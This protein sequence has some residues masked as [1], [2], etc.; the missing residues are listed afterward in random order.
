MQNR[1]IDNSID[2]NSENNKVFSN[3]QSLSSNVP[4]F[5]AETL[6]INIAETKRMCM[7]YFIDVE[8][9]MP[10]EIISKDETYPCFLKKSEIQLKTSSQSRMNLI[11]Y[12][13]QNVFD[14]NMKILR[15]KIVEF[16]EM[17]NVGTTID[18][19]YKID[20]NKL[21]TIYASIDGEAPFEFT[22]EEA[23]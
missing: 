2:E 23:D 5:D 13:G 9:N 21:I 10:I 12:E 6:N 18:I 11:L 3:N 14:Y 22:T 8:D 17:I 7:S 1:P 15:Q 4:S 16:N 19:S 20:A